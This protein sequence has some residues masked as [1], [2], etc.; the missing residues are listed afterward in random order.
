MYPK[1]I[2]TTTFHI[3][4]GGGVRMGYITLGG[5]WGGG[6]ATLD[7]IYI[8]IVLPFLHAFVP[9]G[10][11]HQTCAMHWLYGSPVAVYTICFSKLYY[12]ELS[13]NVLFHL[14]ILCH[15]RLCYNYVLLHFLMWCINVYHILWILHSY[16]LLRHISTWY[17]ISISYHMILCISYCIVLHCIVLYCLVLHCIVL[18]C[19]V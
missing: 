4:R 1:S 11:M 7:H 14:M 9:C 18:H 2:R 5:G 6:M 3:H 12:L 16:V 19:I 15:I 8:Y 13:Y 17:C 10:K